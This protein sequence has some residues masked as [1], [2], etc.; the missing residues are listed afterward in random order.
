MIR[1]NKAKYCMV[2]IL[3]SGQICV[4][5]EKSLFDQKSHSNLYWQKC[6]TLEGRWVECTKLKSF[7]H[8]KS[9]NQIAIKL[10]VSNTSDSMYTTQG[11]M[12]HGC[13][14]RMWIMGNIFTAHT[15]TP[16]E[17]FIYNFY[18]VRSR[19]SVVGSADPP[20][21]GR[22]CLQSERWQ[23]TKYGRLLRN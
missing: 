13:D 11:F 16:L 23:A 1:E 6:V 7:E 14:Q 22:D 20:S 21:R 4:S 2:Y 9:K 19:N 3:T 17:S 5:I 15:L 8:E 10:W 18:I 12:S